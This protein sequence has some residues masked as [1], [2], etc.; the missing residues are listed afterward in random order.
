LQLGDQLVA[1]ADDVLVLLVLVVGAVRLDDALA[2]DSVDCA[3]D[4]TS[5]DELGE[6]AKMGRREGSALWDQRIHH[7]VFA[8]TKGN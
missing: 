7:T 5:S 8:W 2:G 4:A 3:G 6:V 1:L